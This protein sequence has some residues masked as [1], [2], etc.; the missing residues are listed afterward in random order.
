MGKTKEFFNEQRERERY[1]DDRYLD[2]GYY[3]DL[4]RIQHAEESNPK[5]NENGN[6]CN[7]EQQEERAAK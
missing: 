6:L 1:Q 3:F 7:R 5:N 2:D 4:M